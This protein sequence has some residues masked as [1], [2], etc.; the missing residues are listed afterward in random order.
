MVILTS[1]VSEKLNAS[2]GYEDLVSAVLGNDA[3]VV[4][5]KLQTVCE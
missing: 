4:G 3:G 5:V 1:Q 2:G